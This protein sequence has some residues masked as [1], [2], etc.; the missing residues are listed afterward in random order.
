M[1]KKFKKIKIN[2]WKKKRRKK[3]DEPKN[4]CNSKQMYRQINRYTQMD[5]KQKNNNNNN[6]IQNKH[7]FKQLRDPVTCAEA[8]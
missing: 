7:R 5:G 3:N 2:K 4:K 1:N 6:K 8:Y